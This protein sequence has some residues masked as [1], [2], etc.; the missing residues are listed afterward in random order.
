MST[1]PIIEISGLSHTYPGTRAAPPH[2]ALI[3]VAL[4]VDTGEKVALLG[5]NGSGKST[6]L[7]IL[8]TSLKP[9]SGQ[10]QIGG[11]ELGREPDQIRRQIGVVFQKPALDIRMTVWENLRAAGRLYRIPGAQLEERGTGLLQRLGLN[12]RRKTLVGALSGGLARRV[13]LARALLSQP[14]LLILDEPTTG[15]DPVARREFWRQVEA[16]RQETPMSVVLTTHLLEEAD[17]CDRVAILHRGRVLAYDQP[18]VLQR[19]IGTEVLQ[20]RGDDP[21]LLSQELAQFLGAQTQVVD[22]SVRVSLNGPPSLDRLMATFG[23]RIKALSLAHPSLD[24]VFVHLTGEH[25]QAAE[26]EA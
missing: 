19:S 14:P 18:G 4:R 8:M 9:S 21:Q 1:R 7:R 23:G 2:Q 13:E 17:D 3:D 12:D 25:L 6:L 20:V 15:L 24:D 16:L 11:L 26:V 22:Q 5:P 10:V